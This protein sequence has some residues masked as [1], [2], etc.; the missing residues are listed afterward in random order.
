MTGFERGSVGYGRGISWYDGIMR[1]MLHMMYE[2]W[3]WG[4]VGTM[5]AWNAYIHMNGI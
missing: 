5:A 2:Y 4:S 1:G 3:I